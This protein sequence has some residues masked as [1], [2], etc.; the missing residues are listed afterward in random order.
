MEGVLED[1]LLMLEEEN[2]LYRYLDHF[3]I[4]ASKADRNGVHTSVVKA[5]VIR[6]ISESAAPATEHHRQR[7]VQHD[8]VGDPGTDWTKLAGTDCPA[9]SDRSRIM[10]HR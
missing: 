4:T 7:A 3:N 1:G 9:N 6:D 2:A 10:R 5:T 8:E